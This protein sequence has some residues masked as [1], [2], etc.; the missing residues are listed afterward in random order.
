M[1]RVNL[2]VN[3]LAMVG[4]NGGGDNAQFR[5]RPQLHPGNGSETAVVTNDY[6]NNAS[7]VKLVP[8]VS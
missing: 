7:D 4:Q 8:D 3:I 1:N 5:Q 6:G 2:S